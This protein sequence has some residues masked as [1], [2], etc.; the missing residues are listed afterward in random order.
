MAST[1][2]HK[3][4]L[5]FSEIRIEDVPL[6]GGKNASLGEMFREL[7]SKGVRVP[8][9]FAV[10][11]EAYREFLRTTGL[12]RKIRE[13]LKG[14]DANN[15]ENLQQRGRAV[16]EA[17]LKEEIPEGI[18]NEIFAAYDRLSEGRAGGIDVAVRSSAT[19]ED[20]PNASLPGSRKPSS[21]CTANHNCSMPAVA[22]SPRSSP[23]APY[24]TANTR[25]STTSRSPSRSAYSAWCALTSPVRG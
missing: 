21:T 2:T 13:L 9:G 11:A 4:I 19:A 16:R 25:A 8:D 12:D 24:R 10:T 5:P 15:A 14:L 23:T 18:R 1:V 20:L 7:K 6:V 3:W 17:I 22:A